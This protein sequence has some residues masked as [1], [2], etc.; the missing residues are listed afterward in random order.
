M[1][2]HVSMRKLS[3]KAHRHGEEGDEAGPH[4]RGQIAPALL[5]LEVAPHLRASP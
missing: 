1:I 2:D 5:D 3:S 4:L